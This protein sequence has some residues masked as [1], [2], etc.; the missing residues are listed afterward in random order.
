MPRYFFHIRDG[1][2]VTRDDEGEELPDLKAVE[3][4]ARLS[5]RDILAE[6]LAGHKQ[7]NDRKIEVTNDIGVVVYTISVRDFLN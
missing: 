1:D 6:C 4:E 5:A 7:P 3:R 2:H